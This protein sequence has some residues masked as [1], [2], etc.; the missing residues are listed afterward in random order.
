MYD[1]PNHKNIESCVITKDVITKQS[2]PEITFYKKT[3]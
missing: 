2:K 3:A 1:I